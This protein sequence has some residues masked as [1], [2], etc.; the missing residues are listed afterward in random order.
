MSLYRKILSQSWKTTWQNKYLWFFG[1]FAGFLMSGNYKIILNALNGDMNSGIFPGTRAFMKT[2]IFGPHIFYNINNIARHDPISLFAAIFILLLIGT[3]FAFLI[4]LSVVSQIALVNNSA[5]YLT[6]KKN[7]FSG[8]V[9]AGKKNFWPVFGFNVFTKLIVVGA[10]FIIY[11]PIILVVNNGGIAANFLYFLCFIIFF[12]VSVIAS[13]IIKYAIAYTVIKGN[14]FLESIKSGWKLFKDN[15]LVS[16][17]MAFTLF[18]IEFL[19]GVAALLAILILATPF[20][21]LFYLFY[22]TFVVGVYLVIGLAFFISILIIVSVAATV[23]T[24]QISSWTGLFIELVSRGGS[25][26]IV[27]L[28]EDFF[29]KP[30]KK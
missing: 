19:S 1:I 25:S 17:E 24:F 18:F 9:E 7:D 27:R 26:K 2:G 13:F 10:F 29:G 12:S 30:K 14:N 4:W 22:K 15:W 16:I 11:L 6:N 5:G 20:A 21:F 28:A 23:T 8:G 3:L